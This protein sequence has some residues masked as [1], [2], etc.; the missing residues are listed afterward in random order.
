MSPTSTATE[1]AF[2]G[3][4]LHAPQRGRLDCLKDALIVVAADGAISAVHDGESAAASAEAKRLAKVGNL[5]TLGPQHYVLPGMVDLHVHAP[6]W[7]QLGKALD[8]P[9]EDWLQKFT[10][11]L[12]ARYADGGL[13]A[14]V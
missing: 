11:P 5:V 1:R 3:T 14:Q 12:E 10:F 6:Q 9:L 4:F 13:A 8:L 2:R 7:P